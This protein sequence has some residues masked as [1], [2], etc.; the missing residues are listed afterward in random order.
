MRGIEPRSQ[1][2][3]LLL[4]PHTFESVVNG[5]AIVESATSHA[6]NIFVDENRLNLM[7]FDHFYKNCSNI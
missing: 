3:S 7:K 1:P 6:K 5:D 4:Q 2:L